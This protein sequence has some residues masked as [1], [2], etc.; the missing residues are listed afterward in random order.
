M[1]VTIQAFEFMNKLFLTMNEAV[2][3]S[4]GW[5]HKEEINVV[6]VSIELEE[7]EDIKHERMTHDKVDRL[8]WLNLTRFETFEQAE[9]E[10]KQENQL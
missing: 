5:E 3:A 2:L 6:Y 9:I 8:A 4:E 7:L 10:T 1:K